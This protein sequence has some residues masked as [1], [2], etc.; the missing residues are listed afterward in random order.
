MAY[1][2]NTS[3]NSTMGIFLGLLVGIVIAVLLVVGVRSFGVL[4]GSEG[5]N[6]NIDLPNITG[7]ST[8]GE[9]VNPGT[10]QNTTPGTPGTQTQ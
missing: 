2:H 5:R 9:T 1:V 4:D 6:I 3:E 8:G 10:Q 7:G